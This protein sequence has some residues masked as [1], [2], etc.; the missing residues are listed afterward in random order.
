MRIYRMLLIL[1]FISKIAHYVDV[2]FFFNLTKISTWGWG[3]DIQAFR[4]REK[5]VFEH[6]RTC[7]CFVKEFNLKILYSPSLYYFLI[8]NWL[9]VIVP[10]HI[11]SSPH[12]HIPG[13][14]IQFI[15]IIQ[16]EVTCTETFFSNFSNI[17]LLLSTA[18][19]FFLV[20]QFGSSCF[21]VWPHIR[22]SP[23]NHIPAYTIEFN[24]IQFIFIIQQEV[25]CT[26]TF[27]L[28]F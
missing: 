3:W 27:F 5:G 8:S 20:T 6:A 25:T 18:L 2:S 24:S 16:Q 17:L 14:T 9:E 28:Q 19:P 13:Y 10:S 11:R 15:F 1:A 21:V 4:L 12:N 22:S 23:D 7:N 26:E